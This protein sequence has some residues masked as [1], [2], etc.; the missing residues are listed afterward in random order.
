MR[1]FA[2]DKKK[3]HETT[4]QESTKKRF[5]NRRTSEVQRIAE[6]FCPSNRCKVLGRRFVSFTDLSL[7]QGDWAKYHQS[8]CFLTPRDDNYKKN[9]KIF[10][11]KVF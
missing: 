4:L 2:E 10:A 7:F 3:M 9:A 6:Y 8:K 5:L 11:S 1:H